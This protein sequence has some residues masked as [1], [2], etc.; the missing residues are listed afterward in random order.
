MRS[1]SN[2]QYLFCGSK[3]CLLQLQVFWTL[4]Y[5]I[6]SQEKTTSSLNTPSFLLKVYGTRRSTSTEI[7]P[8]EH[9]ASGRDIYFLSIISGH[10]Y[11]SKDSANECMQD[12]FIEYVK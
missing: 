12:S 1:Y 9:G 11:K 10:S 2:Y 4:Y 3:I 7:N 5:Q 6:S 8:L